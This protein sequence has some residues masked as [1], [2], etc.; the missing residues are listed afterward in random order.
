MV[1]LLATIATVIKSTQDRGDAAIQ[2]VTS[3][4]QSIAEV[5]ITRYQSFLVSNPNLAVYPDCV[6]TRNSS[7]VCPDTGTTASWFNAGTISGVTSST[8]ITNAAQ[9]DW[10]NVDPSDR[11]KGQFRL[12]SYTFV[13]DDASKPN[14]APGT[15]TLLVEGRVNQTAAGKED[16]ATSTARLELAFRVGSTGTL[17]QGLWIS[18]NAEVNI[19]SS[20]VLRS[21]IKDSTPSLKISDP[22][23]SSNSDPGKVNELK[24]QQPPS[25]TY[26][27][28]SSDVFPPLPP[29][30]QIANVPTTGVCTITNEL[31]T[32]ITSSITFTPN[33]CPSGGG[34]KYIYHFKNTMD[35][36]LGSGVH[37]TVDAPGQTIEWYVEGDLKI[38]HEPSTLKVTPGTN[39][40][41][42][43]H[44][45]VQLEESV[46]IGGAI[47]NPG[48]PDQV[49]IYKYSSDEM[50]ITGGSAFKAFIFAPFSTVTLGGEDNV[51]GVIWSKSYKG[52][53]KANFTGKAAEVNC[54]NL[55]S[56]F[57]SGGKNQITSISSWQRKSR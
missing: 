55:P 14:Q 54:A 52:N 35:V 31:G 49:Q 40:I 8:E 39:L 47:N 57:C 29:K 27:E 1:M 43:A 20:N 48:N 56:G 7:G 45:K 28:N 50:K 32:K 30:G 4:A 53:D 9:T 44:G 5:G 15:G 16:L 10:Q 34:T 36:Y 46:S 37:I 51:T 3:V 42:Y 12:M 13:A 26:E 21:N 41:I 11:S 23:C 17:Q 6:G 24:A 33:N 18:C 22:P 19:S 38:H 2:Q 25:F